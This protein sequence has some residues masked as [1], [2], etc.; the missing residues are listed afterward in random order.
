ME[1]DHKDHGYRLERGMGSLAWLLLKRSE[2][3]PTGWSLY[4]VFPAAVPDEDIID[5][6]KNYIN[7]RLDNP[8]E[9]PR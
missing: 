2:H 7:Q 9:S 8:D 4:G 3:S 1:F 6:S 5:H